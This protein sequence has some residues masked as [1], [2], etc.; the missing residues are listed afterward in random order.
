ML[1]DSGHVLE[2]DFEFVQVPAQN[3]LSNLGDAF[4][5]PAPPLGADVFLYLSNN[6]SVKFVAT[7]EHHIRCIHHACVP[8]QHTLGVETYKQ[9][10]EV[11][12]ICNESLPPHFSSGAD[13]CKKLNPLAKKMTP[14]YF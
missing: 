6:K 2:E 9:G 7:S 10:S 13:R 3:S 8:P 4:Y 5:V 1:F 11:P 12:A 14:P